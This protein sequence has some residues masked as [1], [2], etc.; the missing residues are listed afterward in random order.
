MNTKAVILLLG[1]C[2]TMFF[3]CN[4][5]NENVNV[6]FYLTDAPT[7]ENYQAVH[8]DIRGVGYSLGNEK[9]ETLPIQPCIIDLLQYRDG[10]DTL[11]SLVNLHAGSKIHQVRLILGDKNTL[12]LQDG[13]I[14]P[15]KVPSGK[16]SGLK[17]N[18]QS[19]IPTINDYYVI[20]DFDA[21]KSIINKGNCEY[22]LKPVITA[23]LKATTSNKQ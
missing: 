19:T 13:T 20:I 9:W 14:V 4:D 3:A 18:V 10:R 11:L 17:I 7:E 15:L 5:S 1:L 22:S 16:T 23:Y 12:T 8:I 6:S 21:E 2:L